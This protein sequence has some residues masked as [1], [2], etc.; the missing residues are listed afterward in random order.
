LS[1]FLT[2]LVPSKT[3]MWNFDYALREMMIWSPLFNPTTWT[4]SCQPC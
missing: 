1:S 4:T 3:Y 2:P